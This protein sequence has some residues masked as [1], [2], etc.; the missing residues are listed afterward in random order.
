MFYVDITDLKVIF[1][2]AKGLHNAV[3]VVALGQNNPA[4]LVFLFMYFLSS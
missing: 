1:L 3:N 4:F 2:N